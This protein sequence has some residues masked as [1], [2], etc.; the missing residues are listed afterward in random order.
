MSSSIFEGKTRLTSQ[1][2]QKTFTQLAPATDLASAISVLR[3]DAVAKLQFFDNSTNAD[4]RLHLVHPEADP[5][6]NTNRL[7]WLELPA[8]RVLDISVGLS[9]LSIPPGTLLY[10]YCNTIP[11]SGKLRVVLW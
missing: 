7:L 11:T 6:V 10:I 2:I 5:S 9:S 4:L 3:F 1:Y 8:N